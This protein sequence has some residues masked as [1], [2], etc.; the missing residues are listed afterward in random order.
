MVAT[1][2]GVV[3]LVAGEE[4]EE[5]EEDEAEAA[6]GESPVLAEPAGAAGVPATAASADFAAGS[7]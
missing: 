3:V 7:P 6:A 1:E 2:A 4:E 5:E